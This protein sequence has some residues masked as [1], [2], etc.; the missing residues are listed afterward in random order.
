M[1]RKTFLL[2]KDSTSTSRV[3]IQFPQ[4]S[5]TS[6]EVQE[7]SNTAKMSELLKVYPQLQQLCHLDAMD[8]LSV[9]AFL[10]TRIYYHIQ[11]LLLIKYQVILL[12][13]FQV[14]KDEGQNN[15]HNL[16]SLNL[17]F[18]HDLLTCIPH[19]DYRVILHTSD[20][21]LW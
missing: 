14:H 6:G 9:R 11:L 4:L 17:G 12:V 2:T 16:L 5:T 21:W 18:T 19:L 3:N 10:A 7:R 20:K 1:L 15:D 13:S 8:Y